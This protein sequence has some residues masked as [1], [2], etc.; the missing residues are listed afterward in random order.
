MSKDINGKIDYADVSIPSKINPP[1]S[2][3]TQITQ[4]NQQVH[5]QQ[6]VQNQT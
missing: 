3:A 5:S 6:P 2:L 4:P 1:N